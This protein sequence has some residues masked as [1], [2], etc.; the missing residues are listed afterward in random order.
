M[1]IGEVENTFFDQYD[2]YVKTEQVS[3]DHDA[4]TQHEHDTYVFLYNLINH[5][6][7]LHGQSKSIEH[8]STAYYTHFPPKLFLR[9]SVWRI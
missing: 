1:N 8:Q 7:A 3:I 2:T 6:K 9:N 5:F 4:T